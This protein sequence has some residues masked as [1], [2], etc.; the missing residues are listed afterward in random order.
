MGIL[1]SGM[2]FLLSTFFI[3]KNSRSITVSK[4]ITIIFMIISYVAGACMG[5][6][7]RGYLYPEKITR[8]LSDYFKFFYNRLAED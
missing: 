5:G 7:S 3:S 8:S 6:I 4:Q 1:A 2:P